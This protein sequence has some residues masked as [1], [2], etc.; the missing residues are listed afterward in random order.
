MLQDTINE[1]KQII[2][3][4]KDEELK[5]TSLSLVKIPELVKET[6]SNLEEDQQEIQDKHDELLAFYE[7]V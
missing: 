2:Q 5:I 1:V 3:E 6:I 4:L 7:E